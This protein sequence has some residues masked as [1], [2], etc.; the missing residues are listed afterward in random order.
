MGA[1]YTIRNAT[2]NDEEQLVELK[3]HYIQFI[4]EGHI[5]N[6]YIDKL[7]TTY[8]Q[9]MVSEWLHPDSN[10]QIIVYEV[11]GTL[12]AYMA[13]GPDPEMEGWGSII[14]V[15][16]DESVTYDQKKALTTYTVEMMKQ[17]GYHKI[18]SWILQDNFRARFTFESFGFKPQREMKQV[19]RADYTMTV[20]R[21]IYMPNQ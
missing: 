18:H 9:T 16:A 10:I 20:R 7:G 8:T 13:Y 6:S 17:Q 1:G 12:K 14:D 5:P 2:E 15:G 11:E 4:Y 19:S 3:A 21:Y